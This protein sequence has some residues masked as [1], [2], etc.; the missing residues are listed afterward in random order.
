VK[1]IV[2]V[3]A[4]CAFVLIGC[5]KDVGKTKD[6]VIKV[7]S[8]WIAK[9]QIDEI[10]DALR[11]QMVA[12]QPE[13]AMFNAGNYY[14]KAAA[15]QLVANQLMLEEAKQ[16]HIV[17]T[18]TNV[19][20]AFNAFKLQ[21]G[22]QRFAQE[23]ARTGKSLDEFKSYIKDGM[24][25]DSLIKIRLA[26]VDT[27]SVK[28]CEDFYSANPAAFAAP[29]RVRISQIML[30]AKKG[31]TPAEK[32]ALQKKAESVLA[33]VKAGKNFDQLAKQYSQDPNAKSG[34]DIGWFK[35]GDMMKEFEDV[36]FNLKKDEVSPVFETPV[37]FH[38]VKK[39][40]EEGSRTKTFD[41]SKN[42]IRTSL[43]FKKRAVTVQNYLDSLIAK[44]KVTY[45]DTAYTPDK[46]V[47]GM[48]Y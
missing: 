25:V 18:D 45:T 34:A 3:I 22:E 42:Q 23:L 27:V 15:R 29:G 6:S 26:K 46:S 20:T 28:E 2:A 43:E 7:N 21:V 13:R 17:Y 38:I 8:T 39:T 32:E 11:Q 41:E 5:G 19:T 10:A 37:G 31:I 12:M 4:C 36:A 16:R 48:G 14:K 1:K 24:V 40:D 44:A 33:Q 9:T 35:R 30:L 47:T